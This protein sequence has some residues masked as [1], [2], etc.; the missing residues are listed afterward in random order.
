VLIADVRG[1]KKGLGLIGAL[2]FGASILFGAF[3]LAVS[4]G[5]GDDG[6]TGDDAKEDVRGGTFSSWN[7]T[8]RGVLLCC[9]LCLGEEISIS[10]AKMPIKISI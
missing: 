7:L 1:W 3:F 2:L 8:T 5:R 10:W 9:L 4:I 6:P